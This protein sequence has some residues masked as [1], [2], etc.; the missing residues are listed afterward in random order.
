MIQIN[1]NG[2]AKCFL[3]IFLLFIL[4]QCN[5]HSS[6][7]VDP[8]GNDNNPGNKISKPW[9]SLEKVNNTSFMPGDRILFKAGGIWN[10]QLN[11]KGTGKLRHP[12]LI[13]MYGRGSKPSINGNGISGL[14]AG[15]VLLFNQ[16]YWEIENLDISNKSD[17]SDI[18]FGILVR[19]HDYGTGQYVH[20]KNCDIHDVKGSMNSRFNGEGIL[21]VAT[22]NK[23]QTN[24]NNILIEN[25]SL[26]NIDRTGISIWSQWNIRSGVNFG[27]DTNNLE[28]YHN[29]IGA[30]KASTNVII[31]NNSL[32]NIGGDGMIV[33]CTK[34]ALIEYN[35]ISAANQRGTSA[36]AGMWPHNSDYAVMQ[37]NEVYNTRYSGDGMGFDIDQMCNYNYSQFNYSHDNKGGFHLTCGPSGK[38]GRSTGNVIR[39]NISQNDRNTV[40]V[41]AGGVDSTWIYNNTIYIGDGLNTNPFGVWECYGSVAINTFISNNIF[42]NLGK[43]KFIYA[44]G[45]TVQFDHNCFYGNHPDNEPEDAYKVTDDPL[46]IKPG[47]GGIGIGSVDGYKLKSESPC[48]SK[49][50]I[51]LHNGSIDYWRNNVSEIKPP[52]IG[53]YNGPGI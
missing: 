26:K 33:S 29:S 51:I 24:Y 11:P 50:K 17:S 47:S 6:Y 21:V 19:W 12:I 25:C 53:A 35:V 49:G 18:R 42:Y 14:K 44:E 3:L 43:G 7:Y 8:S 31:R 22:G 9:K 5:R 2:L 52:N 37:Y 4:S 27:K 10:G 1:L 15:A 16:D 28:L 46:F 40:F 34:G 36:N 13:G 38:E 45:S 30:Y 48:L 41:F 23:K 20:I 32:D 39:Y